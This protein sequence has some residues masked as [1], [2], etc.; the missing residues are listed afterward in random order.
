MPALAKRFG[1]ECTAAVVEGDVIIVV[2]WS[3]PSDRPASGRVGQRIPLVPPFGAVQM[4]WE[5]PAVVERWIARSPHRSDAFRAQLDEALGTIRARRFDAH[6]EDDA[7]A[8]FR[9]AL[10]ALEHDELSDGQRHAVDLLVTE[11][12]QVTH[13]PAVLEPEREY[14][15]NVI[16]S[17]AFDRDF[18]PTIT[19][20]LLMERSMVGA[21]IERAGQGLVDLAAAVTTA[22][23]GR[24]P[25]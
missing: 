14:G 17:A 9:S 5:A 24:L 23:G 15:V 6:Q 22:T 3:G 1:A 16:S 20:S 11:L 12:V 18:R 21:E 10:A 2:E 4:A 13:L 7:A 19:L 8:R 25:T